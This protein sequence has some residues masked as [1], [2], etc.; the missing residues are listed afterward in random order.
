MKCPFCG[1]HDTQVKDS[2]PSDES[3]T[4]KR[5]RYCSNCDGKF[6]TFERIQ[7][8][9]IAV[10]KKE[11]SKRPFDSNKLHRSIEIATRKRGISQEMIEKIVLHITKRL[12]SSGESEVSS[13]TIGQLVMDELAKIDEVAYVRYASVYKD[14]EHASDFKQFIDNTRVHK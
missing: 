9:E 10:I 14:F 3:S 4:I 8:R 11:G 5:R 2:R 6:T 1:F 13:S 12:E 7:V